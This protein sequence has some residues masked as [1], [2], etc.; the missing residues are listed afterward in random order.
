MREYVARMFS[1]NPSGGSVT[2]FKERCKGIKQ[3]G[4]EKEGKNELGRKDDWK[5]EAGRRVR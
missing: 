2:I 4:R 1:F 3:E 5:A